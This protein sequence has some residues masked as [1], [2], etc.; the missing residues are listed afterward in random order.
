LIRSIESCVDP[1][2]VP[3][4]GDGHQFTL[5]LA[6]HLVEAHIDAGRAITPPEQG[7]IRACQ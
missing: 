5:R 3:A 1:R 6:F 2:L 4:P 7:K